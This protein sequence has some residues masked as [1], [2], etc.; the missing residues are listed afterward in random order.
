MKVLTSYKTSKARRG[1]YPREAYN[2]MYFSA[3]RQIRGRRGGG[4]GGGGAYKRQLTLCSRNAIFLLALQSAPKPNKETRY[5][6]QVHD[7]TTS[8]SLSIYGCYRRTVIGETSTPSERQMSRRT[9]TLNVALSFPP[10]AA[11]SQML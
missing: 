6:E 5:F 9:D 10:E 3:F 1:L 2:Q 8:R 7:L 11:R 4:G